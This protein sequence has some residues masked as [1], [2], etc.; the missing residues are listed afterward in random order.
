LQAKLQQEQF[1]IISRPDM[2]LANEGAHLR[3]MCS[4][5]SGQVQINSLGWFCP[6][7]Q[8]NVVLAY[9]GKVRV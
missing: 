3:S 9:G 8:G 1:G 5:G 4:E 6:D 2:F 7:G